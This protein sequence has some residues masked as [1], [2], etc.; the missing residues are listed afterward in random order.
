MSDLKVFWYLYERYVTSIYH[1]TWKKRATFAGEN[2]DKKAKK[3]KK[4]LEE[5]FKKNEYKIERDVK[6]D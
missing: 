5:R 2:G 6:Y 4:E 3:L 1:T